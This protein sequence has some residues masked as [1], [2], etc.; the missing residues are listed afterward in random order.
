MIPYLEIVY[1]LDSRHFF[2]QIHIIRIVKHQISPFEWTSFMII[3]QIIQLKI[4][5]YTQ[6]GLNID[7]DFT[8]SVFVLNGKKNN[9]F[10]SKK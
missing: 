7:W 3:G 1:A 5:G 2:L 9:N 6:F 8:P 4:A 10:S